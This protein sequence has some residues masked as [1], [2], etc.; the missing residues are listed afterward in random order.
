MG[1]EYDIYLNG[2]GYQLARGADGRVLSGAAREQRRDPFTNFLSQAQRWA[3]QVFRFGEGGGLARSD[4]SFR[5]QSGEYV[6]T[7][8]GLL[9]MG[10][11]RGLYQ[12]RIATERV[13]YEGQTLN[14]INV[15]NSGYRGVGEMFQATGLG[16]RHL[17]VLVKRVTEYGAASNFTVNL[18]AN[19]AGPKPGTVLGTVSVSLMYES[20]GWA[21]FIDRW[22]RHKYF[23]LQVCFAADIALTVGSYYWITIVNDQAPAV[24]CAEDGDSGASSATRSTWNGTVWSDGVLSKNLMYKVRYADQID[25][26]PRALCD[27]QGVDHVY[28]VLAAAGNKILYTEG[29]LWLTSTTLTGAVDVIDL[30]VFNSR[31]FAAVF[32]G[33][34]WTYDGTTCSTVWTDIGVVARCF[35]TH[36]NLIWRANGREVNASTTGLA[37]SW[38]ATAVAVGD[39]GTTVDAMVSHG[40]KLLAAKAEG[41]F[42]ISYPSGYPATGAPTAN[43]ML[44]FNTERDLRSWILDWHSGLYFPGQAGV[45]ELKSGVLRNLWTEKVDEEAQEVISGGAGYSDVPAFMSR[46]SGYTTPRRW[47]PI[48]DREPGGWTAACATTRGLVAIHCDPHLNRAD[49]WWYDGRNW[50]PLG[51]LAVRTASGKVEVA[52]YC[53]AVHLWDQGGGWAFLYY[54]FGTNIGLMVVPTWTNDRLSDPDC[55]F[56]GEDGIC[57]LPEFCAADRQTLLDFHAVAV[58]SRNVGASNGY[59]YVSYKIDDGGWA[60]S[61]QITTSPYE[62]WAFPAATTGRKIQLAVRLDPVSARRVVV[63][64]IDLLYQPLPE[65]VTTYQLTLQVSPNIG[66][67]SGAPDRRTASE[68]LSGLRALLELDEPWTFNDWRGQDHTVRAM[69]LTGQ[70]AR[71][72]EES[73]IAGYGLEEHL[74]L[75]LLEI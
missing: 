9:M 30:H 29:G 32:G 34:A 75:T 22:R 19:T 55:T 31:V 65:T 8:S 13:A 16:V 66:R 51:P 67:A 56:E 68:I 4:G 41:I 7:R 21:P 25:A 60:E 64:Q 45:Y 37:A 39:P 74:I 52:E 27:F 50:H 47:A 63:E 49:L 14:V 53:A 44:D 28:R 10:P 3:K 26:F 24:V 69:G 58:H 72:I 59:V 62:L 15:S 5:Y 70:L 54:G 2:A 43:L 61:T 23:W 33:N 73:G 35:A 11:D 20:P 48:F 42:E 36:D 71:Q 38:T 12:E 17:Q 6:D 46:G 1:R 40:G 18:C 57:Y